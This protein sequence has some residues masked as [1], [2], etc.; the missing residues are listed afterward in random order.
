MILVNKGEPSVRRIGLRTAVLATAVVTLGAAETQA[1]PRI[2]ESAAHVGSGWQKMQH[3]FGG[4][5]GVIYA[6][7]R[8]GK[9]LRYRNQHTRP[10][11]RWSGVR[12]LGGTWTGYRH[13]LGDG[14]VFYAVDSKGKLYF[15]N[16]RGSKHK[17]GSGWNKFTKVFG[18]YGGV[19]YAVKGNTLRFYRDLARNGRAR[20][21]GGNSI[22]SGFRRYRHVFGGRGGVIYAVKANRKLYRFVDSRQDGSRLGAPQFIGK[23]PNDYDVMIAG[24]NLI[25]ARHRSGGLYRFKIGGDAA[26]AAGGS[27]SSSS[28]LPATIKYAPAR[29]A[30]G[31]FARARF[32]GKLRM[33]RPP[34]AFPDPRNGGEW[35]RCPKSRPRRTLYPVTSRRACATK[36]IFGEKLSR[37]QYLGKIV[38]RKPRGA[39]LDPRNGGEYWSCPAGYKRAI[40]PPVTS[41]RACERKRCPRGAFRNGVFGGCYTCPRGYKRSLA[42][43]ADLTKVP[44]AC[45]SVNVDTSWVKNQSR[46]YKRQLKAKLAQVRRKFAPEIKA[47]SRLLKRKQRLVASL[48]KAK[49]TKE[50]ARLIRQVAREIVT[51]GKQRALRRASLSSPQRSKWAGLDRTPESSTLLGMPGSSR[52]RPLAPRN[53]VARR[54]RCAP[55]VLDDALCSISVGMV[56]DLAGIA[57]GTVSAMGVWDVSKSRKGSSKVHG[58]DVNS[59]TAGLSLGMDYGLEVGFWTSV[60]TSMAR[61][62]RGFVVGAGLV[63]GLAEVYWWDAKTGKFVGVTVVVQV[64]VSVEL[65]YID[66]FIRHCTRNCLE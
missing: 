13:M 38:R 28:S 19:I 22:A 63:A 11:K 65:E 57:G 53:R 17:I 7:D 9:L 49:S 39:F 64:G 61:R 66:G 62:V 2:V 34:R 26:V 24:T 16:A 56:Y 44:R 29:S 46:R 18:G 45:V 55:G 32:R 42:I 43:G 31:S 59:F 50:R 40:V 35:W 6:V 20:W 8:A 14:G 41:A 60:N 58:Y 15:V 48:R 3:V 25:Y 4:H 47:L 1:K 21:K 30:G 37:A 33:K 36:R 12:T 51:W 52:R 54:A 5:G 10:G 23:L 27:S